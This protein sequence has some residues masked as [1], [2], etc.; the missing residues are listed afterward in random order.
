MEAIILAGGL[1][2]RLQSVIGASPKCMAVVNGQPFLYYVLQYL[3]SNN[4]KRVV[5]SL[6]FKHEVVLE[7][8]NGHTYPF[9]IEHV[10][11]PEPMGTG[12][13]ILLAMQQCT[14]T[15]VVVLNGDTMFQVPLANLLAHHTAKGADATLA[16]KEMHDFERYGV[17]ITAESGVVTSFEEKQYRVAGWING[18]VYIINKAALL[19]RALPERCSFERDY[20]ERFVNDGRFYGLQCDGYFIDIGV[21]SDFS[22]AQTDFKTLML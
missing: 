3:A 8:L 1:G 7:W 20:L 6:G 5:L 12:G 14:A 2:T 16:L 22:Q 13:G 10:I 11:E 4:C 17:V 21:P 9:V 19:E 15:N 18:G